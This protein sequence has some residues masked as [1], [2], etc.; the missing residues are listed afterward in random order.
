MATNPCARARWAAQK[1]AYRARVRNGLAAVRVEV[2]LLDL[3]ELLS[4]ARIHVAINPDE[5]ELG[6]ALGEL[7]EKWNEGRV[8]ILCPPQDA[9]DDDGP[10]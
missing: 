10:A 7:I 2:D 4:H 6:R 9:P 3:V 8:A 1:R 5:K